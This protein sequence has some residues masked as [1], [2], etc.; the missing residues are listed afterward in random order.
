MSR[1]S[2]ERSTSKERPKSDCLSVRWTNSIERELQA[3]GS[4]EKQKKKRPRPK[5]DL[6]KAMFYYSF[7][8]FWS[9]FN[10]MGS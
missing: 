5:S 7:M 3:S 1:T 9:V 10:T 4:A 8:S 6:G 2:P